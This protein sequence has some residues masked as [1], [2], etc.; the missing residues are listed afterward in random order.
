MGSK[1]MGKLVVACTIVLASL[2]IKTLA[3]ADSSRIEIARKVYYGGESEAGLVTIEGTR[4]Q[5]PAALFPC[6]NCHGER[7]QGKKETGV[8]APDINLHQLQRAYR[9]DLL[10]GSP[11]LPYDSRTFRRALVDGIDSDGNSMD[12]SMPRYRLTEQETDSL[13]AFLGDLREIS[14]HGVSENIIRVGIRLPKNSSLSTAMRTAVKSYSNELN[15]TLGIYNRKLQFIE[16]IDDEKSLPVF[17]VIDLSLAY[18]AN[19]T[20][21][22]IEISVFSKKTPGIKQYAL[23]QH[24]F[25]YAQMSHRVAEQE[26]WQLVP[27]NKGNLEKQ[28]ARLKMNDAPSAKWIVLQVDSRSIDMPVLFDQL[29]ADGRHHRILLMNYMHATNDSLINKYP[30]DVYS[31][32]PPGLESVPISGQ[33]VLVNYLKFDEPGQ[34]SSKHLPAQLWTLAAL[35]LLANSLEIAGDDITEARFEKALQ[36]Q[37]DFDT[38]FGPRLS[39]SASKR[40]GNPGVQVVKQ[41]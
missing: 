15:A 29:E 37:V 7:A 38:L 27:V 12:S 10:G 34:S 32:R 14:A 18:H 25:G 9:R 4:A 21:E 8:V 19:H 13:F 1:H 31:L 36:Q 6:V 17:C 40:V 2:F 39:Y 23:Y 26:S 22:K 41:N 5:A 16:I 28:I 3:A 11:R 24:P 35:S 20:G 30:G 33:S